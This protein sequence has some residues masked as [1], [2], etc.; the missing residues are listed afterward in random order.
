MEGRGRLAV[1]AR[2]LWLECACA[3]GPCDFA[4][5]Q[6]YS[7][8]SELHNPVRPSVQFRSLILISV[9]WAV[10]T[11]LARAQDAASKVEAE[12]ARLQQSLSENPV[13]DPDFASIASAAKAALE[14]AT[15]E[16]RAGHV[17]LSLEKL[18]LGFDYSQAARAG[19]DK[20][21]VVKGGLPAFEAMWGKANLQLSKFDEEAA[22]RDWGSVPQAVR[23]L[24]ETAQAKALPLL[25]GG[26]GFA[27]ATA[28]KDGLFYLGEARGEAEFARF[29][30][31]LQFPQK[32]S[33]FA[34]RSILPELAALQEKTNAAFQP[35]RSIDL[36]SRFIALNSSLK[37]AQDL[38]A[39]KSFAGALY[40]YLEAV[41][42]YAML[43]GPLVEAAQQPVV[44]N[45]IAVKQKELAA[46]LQD[47]SIPQL[48]L[49]RA[50]GQITH[51][52]GSE[53]NP[54]E[55]RSASAIL[56]EVLPAYFAV[57]KAA[58][59]TPAPTGN[60]ITL[61]LVRWPYT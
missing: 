45:E 27:T 49:E 18:A 37:L 46:S 6:G 33:A 10:P 30:A 51:R 9:L 39:R 35:P 32:H 28:P 20:E 31:S 58:P 16:A 52:D 25:E 11:S 61:T 12:A 41:R 34:L 40:Q 47:T 56:H 57:Q 43:D 22:K 13:T 24:S 17:Y 29:C 23:A 3:G 53:A 8:T 55:W 4:A 38:N 7:C 5:N 21:A 2:L 59:A 14:S 36:H 42:Q 19:A 48:F 60:T 54:D 50:V 44:K 1:G 26:R 15:E